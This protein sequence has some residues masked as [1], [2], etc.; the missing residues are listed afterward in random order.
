MAP[1]YI[2]VGRDSFDWAR[3]VLASEVFDDVTGFLTGAA[4][5]AEAKLLRSVAEQ[6]GVLFSAV[7]WM[8]RACAVV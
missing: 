4:S 6:W 7:S 2:L 8:H 3:L 1:L 5:T